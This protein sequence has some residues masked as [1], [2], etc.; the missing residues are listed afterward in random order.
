MSKC[1][2]AAGFERLLGKNQLY[3]FGFHCTG[4]PIKAWR[5]QARVRDG[6]LR[7]SPVFPSAAEVKKE[8]VE[9]DVQSTIDN[10]S[11]GKKS[12]VVAK[13]GGAKFQWEIMRAIGVPEEEIPKFADAGHWLKHFPPVAMRDLTRMGLKADWRRSAHLSRSLEI[14]VTI[15]VILVNA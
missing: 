1:E 10:K 9:K 14:L 8:V 6:D 13:T 3:P 12:K 11:K 4:M 2:F 15:L 7:D 5:G